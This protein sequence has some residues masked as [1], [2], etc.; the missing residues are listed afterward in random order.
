MG[1][2]W[3]RQPRRAQRLSRIREGAPFG[4][5]SPAQFGDTGEFFDVDRIYL[6]DDNPVPEPASL[7]LIGIAAVGLLGGDACVE[8]SLIRRICAGLHGGREALLF[9]CIEKWTA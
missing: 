6:T 2:A 8:Q 3:G 1:D 9:R 4:L 5:P 7:A